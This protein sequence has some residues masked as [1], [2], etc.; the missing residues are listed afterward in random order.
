M[1]MTVYLAYRL[2]I[3]LAWM[4]EFLSVTSS[5]PLE[6]V[7]STLALSSSRILTHSTWPLYAAWYSAGLPYESV[8]FTHCG[9]CSTNIFNTS[10]W[11]KIETIPIF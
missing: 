6:T 9:L 1:L 11:P 7:R 3:Y 2:C 4:R 8:R 10:V 5:G